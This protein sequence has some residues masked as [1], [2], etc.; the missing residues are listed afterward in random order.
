LLSARILR[1]SSHVIRV[2]SSNPFISRL[3]SSPIMSSTSPP[4]Q[5]PRPR[6]VMTTTR[7]CSRER[8]AARG[9]GQFSIDLESERI[10]PVG[11]D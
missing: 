3:N 1:I 2:N 5:K 11:D 6:P 9:V 10:K 8:S 4:E 7:I